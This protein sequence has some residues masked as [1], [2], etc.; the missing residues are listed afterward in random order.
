[1]ELVTQAVDDAKENAKINGITNSDFFAG[2]AEEI[3]SSICY[4][5]KSDDVIGI[6]DRST[7]GAINQ[8]IYDA[9]KYSEQKKQELEQGLRSTA[10][11]LNQKIDLI[12]FLSSFS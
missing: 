10:D 5:A 1:M 2:K 9:N 3:L 7:A 11:S 8:K 12:L 6:I 4:R